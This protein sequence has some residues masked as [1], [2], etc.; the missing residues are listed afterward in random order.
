M[1]NKIII[2]F[3]LLLTLGSFTNRRPAVKTDFYINYNID[4]DT[5]RASILTHIR[6]FDSE[7]L[8]FPTNDNKSQYIA[9]ETNGTNLPKYSSVT[10]NH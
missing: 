6:S 4:G 7:E 5:L 10:S 1:I 2:L 9:C 3:I 8:Y